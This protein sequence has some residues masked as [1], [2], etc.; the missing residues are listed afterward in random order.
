MRRGK[1][2]NIGGVHGGNGGNPCNQA[3]PD[4]FNQ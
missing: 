2:P 4:V 1:T 3:C